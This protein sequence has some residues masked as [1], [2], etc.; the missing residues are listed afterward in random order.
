[1]E[2]APESCSVGGVHALLHAEDGSL[3]NT[4][5]LKPLVIASIDDKLPRTTRYLKRNMPRPR[6][7]S[8]DILEAALAGLEAQ[9]QK[10]DNQIAE[11][12]R[13]LPGRRSGGLLKTVAK[14]VAPIVGSAIGTRSRKKRVLSPEARKRIA[15]A[16]KKRWAAVRKATKKST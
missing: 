8:P 1:M 10:I 3:D 2:S 7:V 15:D 12:H 9:K 13:M 16:Q 4:S 5:V 6:T 11:V 14:P